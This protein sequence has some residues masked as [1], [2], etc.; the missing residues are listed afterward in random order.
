MITYPIA[1]REEHQIVTENLR[2]Q[3]VYHLY[4]SNQQCTAYGIWDD[5]GEIMP[6]NHYIKVRGITAEQFLS[7]HPEQ[8]ITTKQFWSN[9]L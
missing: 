8:Q 7:S 1:F 3:C 9:L 6:V 2:V 5:T 4:N